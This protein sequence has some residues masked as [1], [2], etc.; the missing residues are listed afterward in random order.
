MKVILTEKI[1]KLGTIGD[2]VDVAMGYARNYLLPQG[3]AM[4]WSKENALAFESKKSELLAKHEQAKKTAETNLPK[5]M[6]AKLHLIR[7]AGDTG[8]LYGSVSSRDIARLIKDLTVIELASDQVLLGQPIK[9]IG[10]WDLK[11]ALH[12]DVIA[13]VKAYVAQ[14]QDEINALVAGKD[15]KKDKKVEAEV[16]EEAPAEEHVEDKPAD[17]KPAKK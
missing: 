3:K 11:I 7:S 4:R 12:P 15:I 8:H 13:N 1:T 9:E 14:T 10:A 6:A 5:I 16:I 17:K 2:T